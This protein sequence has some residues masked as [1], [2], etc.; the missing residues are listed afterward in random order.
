MFYFEIL[1]Y[2]TRSTSDT[3]RTMV[4]SNWGL[5]HR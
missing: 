2:D 4:A 5:I 3:K 1:L